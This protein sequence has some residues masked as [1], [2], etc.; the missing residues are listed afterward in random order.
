MSLMSYNYLKVWWCGQSKKFIPYFNQLDEKY[1]N[2]STF[3]VRRVD[4]DIEQ[5]TGLCFRQNVHGFPSI[6]L[7]DNGKYEAE[8]EGKLDLVELVDI[9]ESHATPE[10]VA[11]WLKREEQRELEYLA[12][13]ARKD[14]RRR[15]RALEEAAK[16][17]T[18]AK[19]S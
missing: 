2:N 14:E 9:I 16:N 17:D 3:K 18:I 4:C 7:Y 1:K 12:K 10:G 19:S 13:Q 6:Y 15:L 8:Y 11:N 5:S